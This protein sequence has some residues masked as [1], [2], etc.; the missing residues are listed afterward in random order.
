MEA[1][2]VPQL[3]QTSHSSVYRLEGA[4]EIRFREGM[5]SPDLVTV[6]RWSQ[7]GI[8]ESGITAQ[9]SC[10]DYR[11]VTYQGYALGMRAPKLSRGQYRLSSLPQEIIEAL[12]LRP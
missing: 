10:E 9:F 7:P 6:T 8:G 11:P 3:R 4:P 1:T 2:D 12:E 5:A